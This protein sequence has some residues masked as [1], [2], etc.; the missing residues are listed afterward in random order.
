MRTLLV[1]S[2]LAAACGGPGGATHA[3]HAGHAPAGFNLAY[4]PAIPHIVPRPLFDF[5]EQHQWGDYH[6]TFHM[7]RRYYVAGA[8][9]RAWLDEIGVGP[10]P[11]Q[12]GD[13]GSGVEFLVMHRAMIDFLRGQFGGLPLAPTD[14]NDGAT[15]VGAMLDGWADDATMRAHLVAAGQDPSM[16]DA[17]TAALAEPSRFATEDEFGR[18]LQTSLRLQPGPGDERVY[19]QDRTPGIGVHNLLHNQLG[20]GGPIDIGNPQV[21]LASQLFWGLHGWVDATWRRFEATHVRSA[22]EQRRFDELTT[23]YKTH[24]QQHGGGHRGP[25][26]HVIRK[27]APDLVSELAGKA[28]STVITCADLA[29][30]TTSPDCP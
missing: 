22:D 2:C 9:T 18:F 6:L 1:V 29:P 16:F 17:A 27:P 13:V 28:F 10:A 15:T 3:S 23:E 21:N 8:R 24:M 11:L 5:L 26:D 25:P 4:D 30:G 7:A 12:E 19:V 20:D 14:A